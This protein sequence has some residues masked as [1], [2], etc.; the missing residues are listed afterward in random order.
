[1]TLKKVVLASNNILYKDIEFP[2][3]KKVRIGKGGVRHYIPISM[4][5]LNFI[6]RQRD[7]MLVPPTLE[8]V[9]T[10]L[11]EEIKV[12]LADVKLD[13]D[14]IEAFTIDRGA[15]EALRLELLNRG[16]DVTRIS[17]SDYEKMNTKNLSDTALIV[18]LAK[19][20][21]KNESIAK[22]IAMYMGNPTTSIEDMSEAELK[23]KLALL[24]Y[25]GL[26]KRATT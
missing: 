15:E 13:E 18:E 11:L 25:E 24:G 19:R 5:E 21:S 16:F 8:E 7:I 4:D 9:N 22:A 1:M 20:A 12:P 17:H 26:R 23:A 10:R 2:N 6:S 3:G 14:E